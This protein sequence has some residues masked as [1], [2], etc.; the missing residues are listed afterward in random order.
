MSDG[1]SSGSSSSGEEEESVHDTPASPR[2]GRRLQGRQ[3]VKKVEATKHIIHKRGTTVII[4]VKENGDQNN[5]R[6]SSV[7]QPSE[8][9]KRQ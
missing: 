8:H 5:D 6:I 2:D 4:Q 3:S 9:H 7:Q 1:S